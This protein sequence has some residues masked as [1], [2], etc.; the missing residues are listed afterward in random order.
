MSITIAQYKDRLQRR[1]RVRV[2]DFVADSPFQQWPRRMWRREALAALRPAHT[3][4]LLGIYGYLLRAVAEPR[5]TRWMRR[6]YAI[7]RHYLHR[8]RWR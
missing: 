8:N 1:A 4:R 3:L 2:R 5:Y 6:R 7:L